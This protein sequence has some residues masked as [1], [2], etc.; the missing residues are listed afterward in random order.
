METAGCAGCF[1]AEQ[2]IS[3]QGVKT[4]IEL[5]NQ[6]T[7]WIQQ[8]VPSNAAGCRRSKRMTQYF[9]WEENF[10][11]ACSGDVIPEEIGSDIQAGVHSLCTIG[12]IYKTGEERCKYKK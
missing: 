2:G 7:I 8:V 12:D 10:N 3:D 6:K 9:Q 11:F 4:K 1:H 5:K